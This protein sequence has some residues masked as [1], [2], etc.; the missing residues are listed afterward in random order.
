MVV[1]VHIAI[2]KITFI[3]R[4]VFSVDP[5]FLLTEE[6]TL[7]TGSQDSIVHLRSHLARSSNNF[8]SGGLANV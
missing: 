4:F 2:P 1:T 7:G 5:R 3:D 6:N 8:S